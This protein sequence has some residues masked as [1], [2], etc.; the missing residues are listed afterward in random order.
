M[1]EAGPS[2][3]GAPVPER[4]PARGSA[5]SGVPVAGAEKPAGA[6]VD[7]RHVA[8]RLVTTNRDL[9]FWGLSTPER[10]ALEAAALKY[11]AERNQER[12]ESLGGTGEVPWAA[13]VWGLTASADPG[14]PLWAEGASG[15]GA[16]AAGS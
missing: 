9:V 1:T 16:P 11:I 14:V 13:V 2:R 4:S 15:P 6:E 10:D 7:W 8:V 3:A 12:W 5:S